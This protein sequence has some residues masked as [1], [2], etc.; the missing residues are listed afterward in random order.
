MPTGTT[1]ASSRRVSRS[2]AFQFMVPHQYL[3][4]V[5]EERAPLRLDRRGRP[6]RLRLRIAPA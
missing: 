2:S 6:S 5:F 3:W 1:I 4:V